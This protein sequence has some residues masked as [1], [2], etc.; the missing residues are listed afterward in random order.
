M[1]SQELLESIDCMHWDWRNCPKA[2][3]EKFKRRDHKYPT[4][5][6]EA[7]A[8]QRLWIWHAYFRVP[9]AN[10]DLNVVS[11][12]KIVIVA[13]T[14]K[15]KVEKINGNN[16]SLWKLKMTAI[17]TKDKCLAAIGERPTEVTDDSKWAEMDE[18]A[19]ANLHS[20]LADRVLEDSQTSSKQV[21]ALVVTRGRSME[22]G[23]NGSHNH[24]KSKTGKKKNFK[25]FKYG[26]PG[27][28]R[29]DCRGLN[30]SYPEGNVASTFDDGNAL[31]CEAAVA[32]EGRKRFT[33]IIEIGSGM[34]KMYDGTVRTIWDVR[35][36]EG[37]KKN[38]LSLGNL[39]DLGCKVEIQNKIMKILK[40]ALVLMRGEKVAANLY[41]LKGEI[42]EE[43]EVS[44]ASHSPSHKVGVTWHQKLGHMSEQ[45][46]KIL[47]ERKLIRGLIK[48]YLPFYNLVFVDVATAILEEE[49]R[50]NYKENFQQVNGDLRNYLDL[51][52][53]SDSKTNPIKDMNNSTC[54]DILSHGELLVSLKQGY[55]ASITAQS[56]TKLVILVCIKGKDPV[57]SKHTS[58]PISMSK[59]TY[60]LDGVNTA[61]TQGV[62][63]SSKLVENLSDA[64]IYSFFSNQPNISQLDNKDLQQIHP[65]DL[66]EM[67]LRWNIAMLT[68]RAR[69]FLKNARRKL[70]I[71]NKERIG[72]NKSKV[73]CFNCH[74][75]G[76]F[77]RECR[78]PKNQDN[79]NR[80]PIRRTVPV[81]ATTSNALVSQCDGLGY[82]RSDQVEEGNN[83]VPPPYTGIFMP[84][85]PDLVYPSL[86]DF[87]DVNESV[88]ESVVEKPTVESNEP[89]T[90]RKENEALIIEDWVSE[91]TLNTARPVNIVQPKTIVNNAGPI[92]NVINNA[93]STARRPINNRTT[94][95]NSKI[96]QKVN[97]VKANKV[98]TVRPKAILNAV[99]GNYVNVVKASAYFKLTDE[100]HVLL[101]VPRKDNM[102]NVDLKNVV[103]QGDIENLIDLRVKVI[104]CD[105][106][107]EFK[108][109]VMNQFCEMKGIKREFSVARTP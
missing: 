15:F 17:L 102:Y 18:N 28:F 61:S 3:H 96:N 12:A 92:K 82:D 49:N 31:C 57:R 93:Y 86:D 39:D 59:A 40:G 74:K 46:M 89:K 107:T 63:D 21:E 99:Q 50:H 104:R 70:D 101:K 88:S 4:I 91:I 76:H 66:E 105:N 81:E 62:A 27:H 14:T 58:S 56:D 19:V 35:H 54:P 32:N 84:P 51:E 71:D 80:E 11:R 6:L 79:K 7:V 45:G 69:R 109:R 55:A 1:D 44:V 13:M 41:Q 95:K 103:P 73:E 23:S 26:K 52:S 42:I 75:R 90:V 48:V 47:V 108:N 38:L 53:F 87:V 83:V 100:S 77:A 29:K 20:A 106:R 36:M 30:T 72:F 64:V 68:I 10:N 65:D 37:L 24:G 33:D 85:K 97:T 43:A 98:N 67:D 25:C 9:R 22:P 2:L 78:V 94:S 16:F 8:D 60:L 34:V 5:M